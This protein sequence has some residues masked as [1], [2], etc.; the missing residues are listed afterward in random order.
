MAKEMAIDNKLKGASQLQKKYI[1]LSEDDI[2]ARQEQAITEV[3]SML[4]TSR[5]SAC[6]VLR[7][8]NWDVNEVHDSWFADEEKVRKTTGWLKIPVV[9]DPSLNDNKRLRITCQICFDDYPCNRMF[10]A[11]C[12][13][14][15]CRTCLQ[16]YI[17]MSIKDGSGCLFLRC[18]EGECSAIVGDELFDALATYD[19]KLKYCWYLVRS[20]V[21]KDVKWCPAS[22]CK[23]A[24]EFVADADDSCDVLCEC[25]HSFCW[26][27]TMD[28]HHPVDCN[29]V[30]TAPRVV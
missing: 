23:Y 12:G 14:L 30:S 10:G 26:K 21:K 28:A 18:P 1:V 7:H 11:S 22:D 19:D 6:I 24:V 16:T 27:C 4:S 15:F 8:F 20:Y 9:S 17:A 5:A 25:G 29:S 13:H 2:R 3:S